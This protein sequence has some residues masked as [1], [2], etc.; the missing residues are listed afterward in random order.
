MQQFGELAFGGKLVAGLKLF[1]NKTFDLLGD[2]F[3]DF[4]AANGFEFGFCGGT[5]GG[6]RATGPVS[7]PARSI[8][9]RLPLSSPE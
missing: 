6:S 3:V 1:E 9:S 4:V 8:Y 2:A 5:H 7:G